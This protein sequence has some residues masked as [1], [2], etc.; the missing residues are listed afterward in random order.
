MNEVVAASGIILLYGVHAYACYRY[1]P[2]AETQNPITTFFGSWWRLFWTEYLVD[3]EEDAAGMP[4]GPSSPQACNIMP[5]SEQGHVRNPEHAQ[6]HDTREPSD[7]AYVRT[8]IL[9]QVQVRDS[10]GRFTDR[11]ELIEIDND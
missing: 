11:F 7:L 6:P 1:D 5:D 4:R 10:R 2:H 3:P 8:R 9:R